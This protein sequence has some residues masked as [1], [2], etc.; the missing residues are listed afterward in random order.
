MTDFNN[1]PTIIEGLREAYT[2]GFNRGAYAVGPS[3]NEIRDWHVFEV[4]EQ[5]IGNKTEIVGWL[6]EFDI[7]R[8]EF[9]EGPYNSRRIIECWFRSSQLSAEPLSFS[10][11]YV[12][13]IK[14]TPLIKGF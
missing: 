7:M 12:R 2:R 6:Y 10:P 13:N 4:A 14:R 11:R 9:K 5:I 1:N 8:E 3:S